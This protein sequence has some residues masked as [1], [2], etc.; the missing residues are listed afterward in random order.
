MSA[1]A[2]ARSP[3]HLAGAAVDV[4][5]EEPEGHSHEFTTPLKGRPNVVLTPHIA[6]STAEAQEAIGREV[7]SMLI[8]HV[9][10]GG[11]TAAVN[12]PQVE[13]APPRGVRRLVNVHQNVPGRAPE[14]Q[15]RRE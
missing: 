3:G 6:G 10:T 5:P 11:S 2:A 14:S 8:R 4:F 7:G 12:F 1:L 9:R 15:P 13:P